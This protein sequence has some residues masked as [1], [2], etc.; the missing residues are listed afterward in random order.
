[1]DH[2][3]K[4]VALASGVADYPVGTVTMTVN[5]TTGFQDGELI[6]GGTSAA[7]AYVTNVNSAT[8]LAITVPDGTFAA[9]ETITGGTSGSTATVSS[10]VSLED[11]QASI[12]V[13]SA[14]IR[15]NSGSSNQ[16]I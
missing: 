1:L 10:A 8:V 6:T 2:N 5:S 7:T 3:Q 12:D 15:Q 9:G 13:L 11:T 14:V 16:S 4:T